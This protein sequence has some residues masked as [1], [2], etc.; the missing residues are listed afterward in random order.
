MGPPAKAPGRD[1]RLGPLPP[2]KLRR[3]SARHATLTVVKQ[4]QSVGWDP[5]PRSSGPLFQVPP[6]GTR[7]HWSRPAGENPVKS[8]SA[9]ARPFLA[10][11]DRENEGQN[12]GL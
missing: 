11:R 10:T 6:P 7:N 9:G 8:A 4:R 1:P 3:Q 2:R 5:A 12:G